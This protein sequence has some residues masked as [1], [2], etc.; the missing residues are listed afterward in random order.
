MTP[1]GDAKAGKLARVE[2]YYGR[3]VL[4]FDGKI[5]PTVRFGGFGGKLDDE[6]TIEYYAELINAAH[7]AGVRGAVKE[8]AGKAAG[9][10]YR[11]CIA[12]DDCDGRCRACRDAAK[13]RKMAEEG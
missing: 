8:F 13:I 3:H 4:M 2:N 9:I 10:F 6:E 11:R 12:E 1:T 5:W 7:L